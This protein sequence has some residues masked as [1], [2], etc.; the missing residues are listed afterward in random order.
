MG[1]RWHSFCAPGELERQGE[2]KDKWRREYCEDKN[3]WENA[4][5]N[6]KNLDKKI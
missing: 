5:I 3:N 4:K 2:I 6:L 1:C